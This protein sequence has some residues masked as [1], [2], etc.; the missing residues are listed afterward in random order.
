[1]AEQ[2]RVFSKREAEFVLVLA[3][4]MI[5]QLDGADESEQR[6]VVQIVDDALASRAPGLQTQFKVFLKLIRF[7]PL[8]RYGKKLDSLP[9]EDQDKVMRGFQDSPIP[10]FRSGMWGLKTLIYMGYYGDPDRAGQFGYN[11]SLT[12]NEKLHDQ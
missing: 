7:S 4:R 5:P 9:P 2:L 3:R 11:P 12:G 6:K 10:K 8:V 1:M